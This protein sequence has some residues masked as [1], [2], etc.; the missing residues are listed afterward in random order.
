MSCGLL[1]HHPELDKEA[2]IQWSPPLMRS[3]MVIDKALSYAY[4]GNEG[5]PKET[6]KKVKTKRT[7]LQKLFGN[8]TE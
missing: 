4:F 6:K 1:K 7:I 2:I 8:R 5:A 3:I